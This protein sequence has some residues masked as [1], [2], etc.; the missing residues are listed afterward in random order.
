MTLFDH[1]QSC[2]ARKNA[3][4]QYCPACGSPATGADLATPLPASV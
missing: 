2:H 1:C 4:F 3:F